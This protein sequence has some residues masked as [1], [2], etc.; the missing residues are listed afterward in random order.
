MI[1]TR[2]FQE[3]IKKMKK[4]SKA[5]K[6]GQPYTTVGRIASK[7]IAT[8]VNRGGR[9][10]WTPRKYFYEHPILDKTGL[11]RDTAEQSALKWKHHGQRHRNEIRGPEYGLVHQ[12]TGVKTFLG[13]ITQFIVRKYIVFHQKDLRDMAEAFNKAFRQ[14]R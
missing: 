14:K 10:K 4:R 5:F 11:M 9:P 7:S 6:N 2:G 12:Y 13:G 3:A 1:R 8:N